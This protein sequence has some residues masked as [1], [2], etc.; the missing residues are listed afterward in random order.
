MIASCRIVSVE[1][2]DPYR[3]LAVEELLLKS[4][5]DDELIL[6]LWQNDRTVVIGRNQDA[7]HECDMDTLLSEG[8]RLAR[9]FSGGGAV[10][11]DLGN[12]NFTFLSVKENYDIERQNRVILEAVSAF[13]INAQ[14]TGRNDLTVQERKF[15]GCAYYDDGRARFHHGTILIDTDLGRMGRYLTPS[16]SKLSSKGVASVESRVICL[17]EISSD[18]T[19]SKLKE[20]MTDAFLRNCRAAGSS[21]CGDDDLPFDS[22]EIETVRKRFADQSW[23]LSRQ[24]SSSRTIEIRNA[25]GLFTCHLLVKGGMIT[26]AEVF[27]DALDVGAAALMKKKLVGRRYDRAEIEEYCRQS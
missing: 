14:C 12:V 9:R 7:C 6:Y 8:G 1:S 4:V 10:Y 24:I 18:I 19:P 13:G 26:D 22:R 27:T 3:N 23:I 20:V 5:R 15:S 16:K 25:E 21:V 2:T 11:H 17:S